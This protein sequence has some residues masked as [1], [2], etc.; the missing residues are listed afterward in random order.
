VGRVRIGAALRA[1]LGLLAGGAAFAAGSGLAW[2]LAYGLMTAGPL[3]AGY[4]LLVMDVDEPEPESESEPM[5]DE[6]AAAGSEVEEFSP[7]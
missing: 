1:R 5:Q 7:W 2:G 3:L 6:P 4:C